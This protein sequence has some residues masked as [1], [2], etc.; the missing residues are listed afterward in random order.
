M[1]LNDIETILPLSPAQ[2]DV[3]QRGAGAEYGQLTCELHGVLDVDVLL[4]AWEQVAARH[5]LLRALLVTRRLVKPLL[6]VRHKVK[7][8][9]SQDDWR[10]ISQ[11]EQKQRFTG[12]LEDERT[13]ALDISAAPLLRLSLCRVVDDRWWF[14]CTYHQLILDTES[15]TLLWREVL[16]LYDDFAR[17]AGASLPPVDRYEDYLSW[18][19]AQDQSAAEAF[20]RTMLADLA[21]GSE[22]GHVEASSHAPQ[23]VPLETGSTAALRALE[24]QGIAL[25][26]LLEGAWAMLLSRYSGES[27]MF[28]GVDISA[29]PDGVTVDPVGAYRHTL[30]LRVTT[31][32][33]ESLLSWFRKLEEQKAELRRYNYCSLARLYESGVIPAQVRAFATQVKIAHCE[34]PNANFNNLLTS[35]FLIHDSTMCPLSLTVQTLADTLLLSIQYD[36]SQYSSAAVDRMLGQLRTILTAIASQP[37]QSLANVSILDEVELRQLIVEWNSTTTAY[38]RDRTLPQLFVEHVE[39]TPNAIA[40]ISGSKQLTYRELNEQSNKLAHHLRSFGVGPEV[41]VGVC[42]ERSIEMIVTLLA[43]LKAGGAYVPLEADY[44]AERLMMMLE[45]SGLPVLIT[46]ESRLDK[47]PAHWA[48]VVCL[49]TDEELISGQSNTDLDIAVVPDNLAYIMYTSGSTGVPKGV[50]VTHRNVVRLVKETNYFTFDPSQVFLQNAPISFDASTFEIWGS[51]LNGA[52]LVL[53]PPETPT[54]EDFGEVFRQYGVTTVWLTAGLFHMMV[55][56]RP[57]ELAT[58]RHLLAGGD[59]LFPSHVRRALE[60]LNDGQLIN[61][62]GPTENTT[63]TCCCPMSSL[64]PE[65]ISVSIG[66]PISNTQV[67][68]LDQQMRPVPAGVAGELFIGGDGLARGYNIRP[69]LTAERFVPDPFSA[70]PGSRLYRTGDLAR[71]LADGQID[72]IGRRDFQVKVRGFRIELEEVEAAL[73]SHPSIRQC[74]VTVRSDGTDKQ[75]VAYAVIDGTRTLKAADLRNF[76]RGKLPD[77]MV[78]TQFITLDAFPLTT[79]GKI[80]RRALSTIDFETPET[81]EDYATSR[82]LIEEMLVGIWCEILDVS[83]VGIRDN[84]FELGGHSL[85]AVQM[86]SRVREVFQKE[87]PIRLLFESPTI[88]A[89]AAF[90]ESERHSSGNKVPPP[91]KRIDRSQPLPVSFAQQRL[92]FL[93]QLE[94]ESAAYNIPI[95]LRITGELDVTALEQA[96]TDLIERHETLRTTFV[97]NNGRPEQLISSPGKFELSITDLSHAAFS[98]REKE[99][100]RLTAMEAQVPFDLSNGP[101]LRTLLI[102]LGDQDHV[103]LLTMHHIVSDAWSM[104]LLARELTTFYEAHTTGGPR[105]LPELSIQYVDFA[106]WQREWLTGDVLAEQLAYWRKQLGG[107]LPTL[108]LPAGTASGPALGAG[109]N[110]AF[111]R[112]QAE[113]L[114]S[115]S[116]SEGATLFMT[117]L[118]ALDVVL[119]CYTEQSDVVV[120]ASVAGRTTAEVEPLIGFFVNPLVLRADLSGDPSFSELLRRVREVTLDAYTHQDVPFDKIVEE[121]RPD[122]AAAHSPLFQVNFSLDN[123]RHE[124]IELP[125][126]TFTP[127]PVGY[128]S[129][130]FSLLM[131]LDD[132]EEGLGATLQY[133]ERLFDAETIERLA[134]HY[135][136]LLDHIVSQPE[137][138]LSE[139]ANMFAHADRQRDEARREEFKSARRRRL[140]DMKSKAAALP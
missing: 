117:L 120:G 135:Q 131:A 95:G 82:T 127:F 128:E 61:G 89:L 58:L 119:C 125:G 1:E 79:N 138:R 65:A 124:T 93:N 55:D 5:Q 71:H 51:L 134:K 46:T 20:Y 64:S 3:V 11:S 44:P 50:S 133:D 47:L 121:L 68:L 12:F 107:E 86:V 52:R 6:V 74:V 102:K 17:G 113:A 8:K 63:F 96:F 66:R 22:P 27:S 137:T 70:A 36:V 84:F 103:L 14:A 38:P 4:R 16:T 111:S 32:G 41:P 92:W 56:E 42:L 45:D 99:A 73:S 100:Q 98:E 129:T 24:N 115:L 106:H 140:R 116:R 60:E 33:R 25:D 29:R 91:L 90:I 108:R 7:L 132:T 94:P 26:T 83:R 49:D 87:L 13:R 23:Q 2:E 67:Y 37:E 118:A 76:L 21:A 110:F 9:L 123:T 28:I 57:Q 43:I 48:Q 85:R 19:N 105:R 18:L 104:S 34:F 31:T 97:T 10:D 53:M 62:Y 126:L 101:L 75:L 81:A 122:R 59:V 78:P 30:P 88:E 109:H 39:R 69:D 136:L 77:Y 40:V 130:R 114:K 54:L 80:D 139:L 15:A 112:A 72:F 35:R